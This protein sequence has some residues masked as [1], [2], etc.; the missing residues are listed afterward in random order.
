MQNIKSSTQQEI[1]S[2]LDALPENKKIEVLEYLHKKYQDMK[3]H[4]IKNAVDAVEDTWGS[5]RLNK[6]TLGY[7]AED[8]ELEYDI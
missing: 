2:I 5:I 6:N 7:I 8:K 4:T 1:E 3:I